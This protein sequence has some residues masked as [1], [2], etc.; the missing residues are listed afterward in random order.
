MRSIKDNRAL[1][2][3]DT[4]MFFMK[5]LLLLLLSGFACLA[6]VQA[7]TLDLSINHYW[8]DSLY[9]VIDTTL[10]GTS[11]IDDVERFGA[12][13]FD[14]TGDGVPELVTVDRSPGGVPT[15]MQVFDVQTRD[16][17][18]KI[19]LNKVRARL[20]ADGFTPEEAASLRFRGFY[21]WT[22]GT[23]EL[24]YA[25]FFI[26]QGAPVV[27]DPSNEAVI[28]LPP[29]GWRVFTIAD[30]NGDGWPDFALGDKINRVIEIHG[31]RFSPGF[32]Q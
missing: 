5:T 14:A 1:A 10:P 3:A 16:E 27:Y 21:Q 13:R 12:N 26:A 23:P 9:Y 7:Q 22:N 30:F 2:T 15:V 29:S 17:I 28:S 25:A 4:V 19:D 6:P 32:D 11:T 24:P 20:E 18:L 8:D 31:S